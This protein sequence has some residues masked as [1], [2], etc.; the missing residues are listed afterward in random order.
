MD[1]LCLEVRAGIEPANR[2]FADPGLTTWLPHRAATLSQ[3]RAINNYHSIT[4]ENFLGL[5]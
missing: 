1:V 5:P 3:N 4:V 2:G